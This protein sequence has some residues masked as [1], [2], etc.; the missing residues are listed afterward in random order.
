MT[1]GVHR[2]DFGPVNQEIIWLLSNNKS[3]G[4]LD[5]SIIQTKCFGIWYW[6]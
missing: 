5:R 2:H 6:L 1:I 4:I 3:H